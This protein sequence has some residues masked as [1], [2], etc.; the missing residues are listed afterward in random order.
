MLAGECFG[1]LTKMYGTKVLHKNTAIEL[2]LIM[3]H[4]LWKKLS[5]SQVD[6]EYYRLIDFEKVFIY[7]EVQYVLKVL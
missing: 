2:E 5:F 4:S 7:I 3:L 1:V 6:N